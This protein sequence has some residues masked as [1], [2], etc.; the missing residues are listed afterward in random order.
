[1]IFFSF[2]KNFYLLGRRQGSIHHCYRINLWNLSIGNVHLFF[3][4]RISCKW[5]PI[6]IHSTIK[7]RSIVKL[8]YL[9]A[10]IKFLLKHPLIHR[11]HFLSRLPRFTWVLNKIECIQLIPLYCLLHEKFLQFEWLRAVVFQ[12][13]LKYLH[14]KQIIA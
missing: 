3:S 4:V 5:F 2:Y 12:L 13:N 9:L 6:L 1:M 10:L 7:D 8:L 11:S 14:Y